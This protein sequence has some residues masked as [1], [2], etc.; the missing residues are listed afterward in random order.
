M[1]C[2]GL[3]VCFQFSFRGLPSQR[4]FR[5]LLTVQ[6][7]TRP[8]VP[9]RILLLSCVVTLSLQRG[10]E[11]GQAYVELRGAPC[12]MPHWEC[13]SHCRVKPLN[14]TAYHNS[15]YPEPF[16]HL[17]CKC[18]HEGLAALEISS[19]VEGVRSRTPK[20]RG[21]LDKAAL[22]QI[23]P[24]ADRAVKDTL[25]SPIKACLLD[26]AGDAFIVCSVRELSES[27]PNSEG[28][29]PTGQA[30]GARLS[31]QQFEPVL[32]LKESRKEET[33]SVLRGERLGGGAEPLGEG[34]SL[35]SQLAAGP[36][37][38]RD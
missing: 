4:S 13:R 1:V 15:P 7:F 35:P 20:A 2:Q 36:A 21:G 17:T 24:S 28:M 6:I 30:T 10:A 23:C 16:L 14:I 38:K 33:G 25:H 12:R 31:V 29:V 26:R 18:L 34:Q 19:K 32:Q 27:P 5:G 3:S 37:Q 22:Y 8:P 11:G 9:R